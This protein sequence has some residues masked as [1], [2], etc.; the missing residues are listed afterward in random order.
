MYNISKDRPREWALICDLFEAN[1]AELEVLIRGE[2]NYDKWMHKLVTSWGFGHLLEECLTKLPTHSVLNTVLC[3]LMEDYNP[4]KI[5]QEDLEVRR[6][7]VKLGKNV[8][9]AVGAKGSPSLQYLWFYW[10]LHPKTSVTDWQPLPEVTGHEIHVDGLRLEDVGIYKCLVQHC[11]T[12]IDPKGQAVP[13][14][15]TG[16]VELV[17]DPASILIIEHPKDACSTLLGSVEFRCLAES[18]QASLIYQWY[19]NDK[20]IVGEKSNV[21][22]LVKVTLDHRGAFKCIITGQGIKEETNQAKLEVELPTAEQLESLQFDDEE[23]EII[24]QPILAFSN[25]KAAV[26]EK[27]HLTCLAGCKYTLKFEWLKRGVRVDLI[28]PDSEEVHLDP[29]L[30]GLGCQLVDEIQEVHP[31]VSFY[32]YQCFILCPQTG[33][34]VASQSVKIPVSTFTLPDKS[35]PKFKIALLICQEEYDH[36]QHFQTLLAPRS[37]GRAVAKALQEIDFEIMLLSNLTVAEIHRAVE[38]FCSLIDGYTYAFFYFNG[39]ALG[40][41]NDIYLVGKDS[42]LL[43]DSGG[44]RQLVWHGDIEMAVGKSRPLLT[45]IIYDSCRD[46]IP[47]AVSHLLNNKPINN[48]SNNCCIGYGTRQSMRSFVKMDNRSGLSQSLYT[49][50]LLQHIKTKNISVGTMFERL[51]CSFT[52]SEDASVVAQMKPEFKD[53]TRQAFSLAAPLRHSY[54]SRL[55]K[56]FFQLCRFEALASKMFD[57]KI[58]VQLGLS[59]CHDSKSPIWIQGKTFR[60]PE[61]FVRLSLESSLFL[62]EAYL[63]ISVKNSS[64]CCDPWLNESALQVIPL[65]LT[66]YIQDRDYGLPYDEDEPMIRLDQVT[67]R[68]QPNKTK[69]NTF[70]NLGQCHIIA[71]QSVPDPF[72]KFR[73]MLSYHDSPINCKGVVTLPVP[74][75]QNMPHL[76]LVN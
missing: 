58:E 49:K 22:K 24:Q 52:M 5:R 61:V 68:G 29:E 71:L 23:I 12:V 76:K 65:N 73:L 38:V 28:N 14:V 47:E 9:F 51:N 55:H 45:T 7:E 41:G 21:L 6:V 72:L 27:V 36:S 63:N 11:M 44:T 25:V 56:R 30:V 60:K 74:L 10:P 40:H 16:G 18:G 20:L 31:P 1:K 8:C 26:G 48:E 54:A 62:N 13:G 15:Y 37:D 34:R 43:D 64:P 4:I 70:E 57:S 67:A 50:Y 46:Q 19:H 39:H 17:L 2:E 75:C 69:Y 35:L 59:W 42:N 53:S 33:Q 3:D 66:L 32:L